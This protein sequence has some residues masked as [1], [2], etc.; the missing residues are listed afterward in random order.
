MMFIHSYINSIQLKS[1][2]DL[3]FKS[4]LESEPIYS[5]AIA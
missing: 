1:K 3:S 4:A 5:L 2:K